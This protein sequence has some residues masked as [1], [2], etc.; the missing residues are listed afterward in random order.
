MSS[1]WPMI[2]LINADPPEVKRKETCTGSPCEFFPSHEPAR[3]FSWSNDF[4]ASD[5][6][7]AVVVD[8]I[9]NMQAAVRKVVIFIF[10]LLEVICVLPDGG[11]FPFRTRLLQTFSS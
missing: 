8:S 3:D 2:S 7:K 9:I 1:P 6:A 11:H 4:C 10:I 5:W